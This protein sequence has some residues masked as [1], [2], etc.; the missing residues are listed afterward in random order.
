[1]VVLLT[2]W[3]SRLV[4]LVNVKID[5]FFRADAAFAIPDLYMT[6]EAEGYFYAT[7]R[8]P[9]P[10]PIMGPGEKPKGAA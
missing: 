4:L 9:R 1:V 3:Q 6:M 5:R 10:G 7:R 8:T 2:A